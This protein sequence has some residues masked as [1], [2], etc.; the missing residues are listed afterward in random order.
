MLDWYCLT[1]RWLNRV[2]LKNVE[3]VYT[4]RE[5]LTVHSVTSLFVTELIF[6][7]SIDL[8]SM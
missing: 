3:Q 2:G 8:V 6:I 1:T 4:L 5:Y 7:N